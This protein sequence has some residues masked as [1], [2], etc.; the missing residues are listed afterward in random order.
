M[1]SMICMRM[2]MHGEYI[3]IYIYIYIHIHT[4]IHTYIHIYL[5][6]YLDGQNYDVLVEI[7][8]DFVYTDLLS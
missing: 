8:S 2:H 7:V 3:Y 4:Y 5:L 6:T 1:S